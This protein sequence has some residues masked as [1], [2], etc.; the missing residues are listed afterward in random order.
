MHYYSV[1][2][3]KELYHHGIKGQKWGVRRFRNKDGSLTARGKD[4][5]GIGS[6]K[7]SIRLTDKQKRYLKIGAAVAVTGLAVYG[8]YKFGKNFN[9][10]V[11]AKAGDIGGL[12]NDS[13]RLSEIAEEIGVT[14]IEPGSIKDDINKSNPFY[15]RN[16]SG[17]A[18]N[19]SHGSMAYTLRRLGFDCIAKPMSMD[20]EGG[21]SLA[22]MGRYF[23]GIRSAS[24][25]LQVS[26][27]SQESLTRQL[28]QMC[29]NENGAVGIME[30]RTNDGAHFINW[31]NENGIVKVIDSQK[32]DFPDN[33]WFQLID[34]YGIKDITAVR[35][36][37]LEI[38]TRNL[39]KIVDFAK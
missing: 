11:Y 2:Y 5:Y 13:S 21:I 19:C 3:S 15:D 18:H 28:L 32:P 17:Y 34:K 23:R 35:V 26:D 39:N 30:I 33:A 12:I 22:E 29:N 31:E 38:V 36:D 6:G 7:R 25:K 14:R 16:K 8:A 1:T 27:N 10:S 37:D 20:E 9:P 4:R 24:K